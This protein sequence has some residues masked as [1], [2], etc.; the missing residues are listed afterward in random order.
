[1]SAD[2]EE[3]SIWHIVPDIV[4]QGIQRT[5]VP[6]VSLSKQAIDSNFFR[7]HLSNSLSIY[8]EGIV[9]RF[10]FPAVLRVDADSLKNRVHA[11][12]QTPQIERLGAKLASGH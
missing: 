8:R 12:S 4:N 3:L 6:Y 2:D 5:L 7:S 1:M 9:P 10:E 11:R